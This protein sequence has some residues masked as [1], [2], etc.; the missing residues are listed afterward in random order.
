MLTT[1]GK[2]L[3]RLILNRVEWFVGVNNLYPPE[4]T[5]FRKG[6]CSLDNVAC[7]E[8]DVSNSF[9]QRHSTIAILFDWADAYG[10]VIHQNCWRY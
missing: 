8:N 9:N 3:E 6:H 10:N 2:I 5:G 1:L 4:Q 7:L